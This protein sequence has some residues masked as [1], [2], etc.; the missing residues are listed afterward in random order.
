MNLLF[1]AFLTLG[2]LAAVAFSVFGFL[3]SYE[4]SEAT[5]RLPWQIGYAV[6]GSAFLLSTILLWRQGRSD[7]GSIENSQRD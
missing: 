5:R 6:A 4:Y 1:R 2:L 7:G 3:A